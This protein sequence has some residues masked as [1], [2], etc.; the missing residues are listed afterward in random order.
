MLYTHR[1][2]ILYRIRKMRDDFGIPL[3]DEGSHTELLLGVSILLF[4]DRGAE[5][6]MSGTG[7]G[8]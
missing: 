6:F 2:T 8:M 5:F 4:A 3:D 1:N 7:E